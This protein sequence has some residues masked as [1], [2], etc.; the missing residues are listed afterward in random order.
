[1][2][3]YVAY[4]RPLQFLIC[5]TLVF[6]AT[7]FA[8]Q[9]TQALPMEVDSTSFLPR[10]SPETVAE[11]RAEVLRTHPNLFEESYLRKAAN[12]FME[13]SADELGLGAETAQLSFSMYRQWLYLEIFKLYRSEYLL[14]SY[15]RALPLL[16]EIS[17]SSAEG[18]FVKLFPSGSFSHS[19][20]LS[21]TRKNA[22]K[23]LQEAVR[24][25]KNKENIRD[26]VLGSLEA[27][28]LSL[29]YIDRKM[30]FVGE[31]YS[32]DD[33]HYIKESKRLKEWRA[34][35]QSQHALLLTEAFRQDV[36]PYYKKEVQQALTLKE[37]AVNN[38]QRRFDQYIQETRNVS[39][40]V[41]YLENGEIRTLAADLVQALEVSPQLGFR[42]R[43]A[44][45]LGPAVRETVEHLEATLL[46]HQKK[47]IDYPL[48]EKILSANLWTKKPDRKYAQWLLDLF[49]ENVV[50][51]LIIEDFPYF[52]KA[53][54]T[55]SNVV[56]HE[57]HT[58][59]WGRWKIYSGLV[60]MMLFS[61]L[62]AR[63]NK[64]SN[65]LGKGQ[66]ILR[67][68]GF[69]VGGYISYSMA[70]DLYGQY[71]NWRSVQRLSRLNIEGMSLTQIYQEESLEKGMIW[72]SIWSGVSV[73][74]NVWSLARFKSPKHM[75]TG[76]TWLGGVA[77]STWEGSPL[78]LKDILFELK[79]NL[80][81]IRDNLKRPGVALKETGNAFSSLLTFF[82]QLVVMVPASMPS[83]AKGLLNKVRSQVF[84]GVILGTVMGVMAVTVQNYIN[85]A[86]IKGLTYAFEKMGYAVPAYWQQNA[87]SL[88][89]RTKRDAFVYMYGDVF[90]SKRVIGES[91]GS[92]ALYESLLEA[93]NI[94]SE[95]SLRL[96]TAIRQAK[97][98]IHNELRKLIVIWYEKIE[99]RTLMASLLKELDFGLIVSPNVDD[100][101]RIVLLVKIGEAT[102]NYETTAE[103]LKNLKSRDV[104]PDLDLQTE[105]LQDFLRNIAPEGV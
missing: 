44:S 49:Q 72:Q 47:Y 64:F 103:Q 79:H 3:T 84:T 40:L 91:A 28:Y 65:W 7:I 30:E 100:P 53:A 18:K 10:K 50:H 102:F 51:W 52:Q 14:M 46:E 20:R 58:Q 31:R 42:E 98:T 35:I 36:S 17:V 41:D 23:S 75:R 43:I 73:F 34:T 5:L 76:E 61:G 87:L 8:Q 29:A 74:M 4:L 37:R 19:P 83:Y 71:Q 6:P 45:A 86:S 56:N 54:E 59:N 99:F 67:G 55:L 80:R 95:N 66:N 25:K 16:P 9:G 22:L 26:Q 57:V 96:K 104:A 11:L 78:H 97:E 90:G 32:E 38:F 1:M 24:I 101:A 82:T 13:K 105:Q 12:A 81:G 92:I 63:T 60:A 85:A 33:E 2:K 94:S 88:D 68:G 77:R 27:A 89:H 39:E 21:Q 69:A 15:V 70:L 93:P 48:E 62:G